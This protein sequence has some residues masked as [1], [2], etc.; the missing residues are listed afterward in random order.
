MKKFLLLL[1]LSVFTGAAAQAQYFGVKG[2]ANA[3]VLDGERIS[4]KSD[5]KITYHA[6]IFYNYNII[7]PLSIRPELLYSLQGGEFKG[8]QEDYETKLH[9]LNLP[10]L[11]DVK[12]GP[13]HLQGGPQFGVL[14]TAK[15]TGVLLT[16]YSPTGQAQYSNVSGQVT[17]QYKKQDYSLCAGLE[18]EVT[19]NLSLG[20]R[21]NSGLSNVEDFDDIRSA[22]DPR[23][24]NRV[25]QGYLAI[26]M[27]NK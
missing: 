19:K 18:L 25:F 23:L 26:R 27:S 21:F 12:I 8:G 24:K 14:L 20:G 10:L 22:N 13:V 7:G 11:L 5:Y 4:A 17:D 9:Y 15:E 16:G 1:L 3:A 6:G 2:G